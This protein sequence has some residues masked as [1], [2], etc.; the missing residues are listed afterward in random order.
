MIKIRLQIMQADFYEVVYIKLTLDYFFDI[1]YSHKVLLL[2]MVSG[3]IFISF[4]LNELFSINT[5]MSYQISYVNI[6]K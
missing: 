5:I 3:L 4:V 6:C 1:E 2:L